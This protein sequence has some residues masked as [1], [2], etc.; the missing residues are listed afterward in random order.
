MSVRL[1]CMM[2][3]SITVDFCSGLFSHDTFLSFTFKRVGCLISRVLL[4]QIWFFFSGELCS[5]I[6]ISTWIIHFFVIW[7]KLRRSAI[8]GSIVIVDV[9]VSRREIEHECSMVEPR[10]ISVVSRLWP[11]RLFITRLS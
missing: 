2:M 1:L 8:L 11:S 10:N 6:S 9:A 4:P 5:R 3:R 7:V